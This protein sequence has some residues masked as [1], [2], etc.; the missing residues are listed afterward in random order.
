MEKGLHHFEEEPRKKEFGSNVTIRNSWLRHAQKQSG[1]VFAAGATGLTTSAIS[2][3]GQRRASEFGK[4]IKTKTHGAKGF[5]S[6]SQRTEQTLEQILEGYA[7]ENPGAPIK[8]VRV[9]EALTSDQPKDFL[10]L[11]DQRFSAE[12][13]K[14]LSERGLSPED[15]TRLTPD[16]QEDI[17][18]RA[19]EPVIREWLDNLESEL[20]KLYPPREAAARF[21]PIFSRHTRIAERLYSGSEVDLIHVTHKSITEPFLVSGALI[22]A[23]DGKRITKLEELGGS[24]EVLGKWESDVRTDEEGRVTVSIRIRGD[25]YRLDQ[26]VLDELIKMRSDSRETQSG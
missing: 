13:K 8:N 4:T 11:Y 26:T 20:A 10:Q 14:V 15:F 18:E 2:E 19:E 25:E 1:E 3:K 12:K 17:A 23:S 22:R 7:K 24:L 16:E 21:A 6:T 9:R 5:V